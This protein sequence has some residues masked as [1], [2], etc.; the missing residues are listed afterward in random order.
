MAAEY[1]D[2]HGSL[3]QVTARTFVV[4]CQAIETSR[5]LLRST[6]PRFPSGLANNSGQ[7]GRNLL[8]SAGGSGG[9]DLA[10][11]DLDDIRAAQLRV[12]G[13]F[14][15]RALDDWYVIDDPALPGGRVKG[16][17][18]D[19]MLRHPN[20]I[21]WGASARWGDDGLVWG[22]PLKRKLENWFRLDRRVNFEA[23]CDWLSEQSGYA[24]RLPTE[25]E[26]EYAARAGSATAY[27][28]GSTIDCTR[29]MFANNP[30]K[31]DACVS[32]NRSSGLDPTRPAPVR[33][34]PPNAWGLYDMH[35][36]VWEWCSDWLAPWVSLGGVFASL[37][38]SAV[39]F[40]QFLL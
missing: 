8:F 38:A 23:F 24:V 13:P 20:P 40:W 7:V 18:V 19:F 21:A 34:Y 28:W 37:G 27:S 36:N 32:N 3:R 12:M 2:R 9:G 17:I 22:K 16:G 10:Y 14:V 26:W 6:G 15:N 1:F 31:Y 35:G 5:L 30:L 33:R 39:L 4:A 25:V 29:A 11:A